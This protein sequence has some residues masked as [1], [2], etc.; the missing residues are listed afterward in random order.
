MSTSVRPSSVARE[1]VERL[2]AFPS[3]A[4]F[5]APTPVEELARLRAALGGHGPRLI[6]KRDDA[7]PFGFGGNKVRKLQLVLSQAIAAGADA[8]VTTGGV[9]SNHARATAAG[10]AK[11]GLACTIV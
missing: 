3:T 4:L 5:S 11:L 2:R 7:I 10:A 8:L 1:A 9:Q 6:V